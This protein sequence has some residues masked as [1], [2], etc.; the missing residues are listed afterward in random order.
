MQKV[1]AM[2]TTVSV[3]Y[4]VGARHG[5]LVDWVGLAAPQ[6]RRRT[7]TVYATVKSI[8][9]AYR[10]SVRLRYYGSW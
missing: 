3:T 1:Y 2:A 8:A 7:T 9:M 6:Y 5:R 10:V 4:I